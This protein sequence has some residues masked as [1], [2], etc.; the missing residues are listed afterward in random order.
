MKIAIAERLRPFSHSPGISCLIPGT[1]WHVQAF[2]MQLIFTSPTGDQQTFHL[3]LKGPVAGF[4]L[5]QD[6]E[7][8]F[9]SLFG[10]WKEGFFSWKIEAKEAAL[11]LFLERAPDEGCTLQGCSLMRKGSI[12]ICAID[13][14]LPLI[15]HERFSLGCHKKQE[16]ESMQ[17]RSDMAE[18]AP[19]WMRL[20]QLT[21]YQERVIAADEP[22]I[23]LLHRL[24]QGHFRSMFLPVLKDDL[25]QGF[26]PAETLS[27]LHEGAHLIRQAL[28]QEEI[29][30]STLYKLLPGL[31]SLWHCGR[32]INLS[33]SDG[34]RLDVEWSKKQLR[35]L[36]IYPAS[37][38]SISLVLPPGI[39]SFRLRT[40]MEKPG[41]RV[42]AFSLLSLES[43]IPIFLDR[44]EK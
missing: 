30:K 41:I 20:A 43:K 15:S 4:T 27:P 5:L 28:F 19:F 16:W 25:Y 32:M 9:V 2:P 40:S 3:Q 36:V 7:R 42:P 10:R 17:K 8:G 14:A 37:S 12:R 29:G 24:F 31:P 11:W 21:P 18:I 26:Y 6:L 44:F 35:R 34:N 23:T 39:K 33:A 13:E 1:R 22:L 38:S